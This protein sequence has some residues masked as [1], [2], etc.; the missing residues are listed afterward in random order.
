V[1]NRAPE[2]LIRALGRWS[3]RRVL[4]D[5][6]FDHALITPELVEIRYRATLGHVR[7]R[8]LP[9]LDSP[10]HAPAWERLLSVKV[11]LLLIYGRQDRPTTEAQVRL[12]QERA[13]Q[14]DVRLLDRCRHLIP[15]DAA[16]ELQAAMGDFFAP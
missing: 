5:Q 3:V 7:E 15:L 10:A 8:P 9:R 12:L 16:D 14:L 6:L 11:P 4:R 13:P 1:F 2:M